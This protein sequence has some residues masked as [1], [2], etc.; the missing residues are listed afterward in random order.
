VKIDRSFVM[1]LPGD[2]VSRQIVRGLLTMTDA[3]GLEVVAEGVEGPEHVARLRALGCRFAQ[4]YH[5][6][7]PMRADALLTWLLDKV[8]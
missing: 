8:S 1:Q 7:R 5:Y 4:G 6:A 2:L 3:L